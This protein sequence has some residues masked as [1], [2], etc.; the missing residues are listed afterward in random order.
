M[1]P[2]ALSC[3]FAA[4]LVALPAYSQS[5]SDDQFR[6]HR[7]TAASG[8]PF[9]T[10]PLQGNVSRLGGADPP[11]IVDPALF[12]TQPTAV[13]VQPPLTGDAVIDTPPVTG[14]P[15]SINAAPQMY[16]GFL[17]Q[18]HPQ[19][20]ATLN[21]M[22]AR[23]LVVVYDKY[24]DTARTLSDA[25]LKFVTMSKKE[26]DLYDLNQ[27]QVLVIDCG[28]QNLSIDGLQKV[29][30][31]VMM[32]GYLFTTDWMMAHVV[33]LAF[34]GYI[35]W[36]GA[37]NSQK[38]YDAA[39]VGTEPVLFK[40]V[41]TNAPWKMDI[42]CHLIRVLNRERVR[43]LAVSKMLVAD[44]PDRQGVLAVV[45]PFE[46]GYVMHMTS[47]FDRNQNFLF[48]DSLVDPAPVIGISLRQALALNY[49]VAGLTGTKI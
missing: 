7:P 27:A 5:D 20:S 31:F 33:Q 30:N 1:A 4:I 15:A 37:M 38:M 45:F 43:V 40:R 18:A 12:Q 36:N 23:R 17:E 34:P 39:I 35:A 26:F 44:D 9:Q 42:H 11:P 21:T 29:R 22:D 32:G 28:P 47:H 19:F 41:V 16:R 13:P 10:K 14:I 2:L 6:L 49:I 8:S 46:R 3:I 25:G 24:D 48:P